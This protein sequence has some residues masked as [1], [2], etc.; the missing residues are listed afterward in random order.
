MC[1][2]CS[3]SNAVRVGMFVCGA[4]A[5][6]VAGCSSPVT[7]VPTPTP[8][9]PGSLPTFSAWPIWT[10]DVSSDP[11]DPNSDTMIQALAN[12]GGFGYGKF[13][14][15]F[16]MFVLHADAKAPVRSW[17]QNRYFGLPDSDYVPVPIPAGGAIEGSPSDDYSCDWTN[18]DCYLLVVDD[19]HRKLYEMWGADI[20]PTGFTGSI[21]AVWDLDKA[22]PASGRGEQCSSADAGGLPIAPLLFTA[23]EVAAGHIDHAIRFLL[24]NN[25]IQAGTYAH[26]S[27]HVGNPTGSSDMLPYGARLRLKSSFDLNS[28]PNDGARVVARAL[29]KYGMFLADGGNIAL[30]AENDKFT[31]AK[32][33]GLLNQNDLVGITPSDFEVVDFPTPIAYT[34][35]CV[36]N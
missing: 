9:A 8:A 10:K 29:M 25:R 28:L 18:L 33:S 3:M 5:L 6:I 19:A 4:I 26:P 15:D 22:Y 16:S 13:A 11:V 21:L 24:P 31:K 35:N 27:T 20:E 32:W 36:R 34:G 17:V 12:A 30:T 2:T 14:I 7:D 1:Y 23:D